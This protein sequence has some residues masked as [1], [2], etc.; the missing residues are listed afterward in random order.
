MDTF[1]CNVCMA[2]LEEARYKC[3]SCI[4]YDVCEKVMLYIC[5]DKDLRY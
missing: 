1:V 2:T 4:D 5:K 3:T